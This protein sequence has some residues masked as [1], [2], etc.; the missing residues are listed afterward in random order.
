[1]IQ[2]A[3]LLTTPMQPGEVRYLTARGDEPLMI[4]I[5]CFVSPPYPPNFQPCPECGSF[6]ARNDE[7]VRVAADE[8]VFR[9]SGGRLD[10]AVADSRGDSRQ[11][12]IQVVP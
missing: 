6:P 7:A 3:N 9:P 1:M 10:V 11:F 4:E 5:K 2:Y 8:A 12:S